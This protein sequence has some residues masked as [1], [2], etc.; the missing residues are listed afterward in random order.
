MKK[1]FLVLGLGAMLAFSCS[2]D[3]SDSLDYSK[4]TRKWYNVSEKVDGET[5]AYDDH[6]TCGKD[7][8]EFMDTGMGRV[9]DVFGCDGGVQTDESEFAW[10][11]EGKVVTVSS[12][13]FSNEGTI[14]KLNSNTL[15]F[16]VVY[17][18]DGDGEDDEVIETY[19]S[20]P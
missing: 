9:V 13:G 2:S 14:T 16:K 19:T 8:I 7:Y 11:R 4:L 1:K 18:W 10:V 15:Q 5:Y 20:T 12:F 3:D 6:E 17:D